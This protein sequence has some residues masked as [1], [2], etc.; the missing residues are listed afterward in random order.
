MPM[1]DAETES[2]DRALLAKRLFEEG[3]GEFLAGR[4]FE[5]HDI[6][7]DF[8]HSLRGPDRRYLQGLIHLAVGAYHYGN[9]N[10]A[11]ARSQWKKA[12]VKVGEYPKCHWGV[13]VSAWVQWIGAYLDGNVMG[14]LPVELPFQTDRFPSLLPL[15]PE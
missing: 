6:W 10:S 7:E 11:G 5:A 9:G 14:P 4:Y 2:Q 15:A 12:V 13:D 8:W 1:T 3:R